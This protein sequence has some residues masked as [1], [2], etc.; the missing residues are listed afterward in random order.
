MKKF[1]KENGKNIIVI[2]VIA[3]L[4]LLSLRM[5]EIIKQKTL[6]NNLK[7]IEWVRENTKVE[8]SESLGKNIYWVNKD[9]NILPYN[10]NYQKVIDEELEKL[11]KKKY[12]FE[13][14]LLIL[15]PYGTNNLGLNIYFDTEEKAKISYTISVENEEIPDFSRTLN[16]DEERDYAKKHQYQLIGLVPEEVNTIELVAKTKDGNKIKNTITIDMSEVFCESDTILESVEGDSDEELTEGLYVL[17]GLDKA[18]NAN[19]Y[20]Y[21]NNGILRA[22]LVLTEY[23]SDRIIFD[24]DKLI[25]SYDTN[26]IAIIDRLGRIEKE[27]TL[28]EYVMHHD[29]VLDKKNNKLLILVNSKGEEAKTIEDLVISLNLKSGEITEIIDMKDLLPEIYETAE[30][31]ESGKN[32]YGGTGLDWIH[33]N[34]LSLIE[35]KEDVVL[36]AREI[37][38]IIYVEDIYENP[39]VKYLIADPSVYKNTKYEDLML[40]QIGDFVNHA[41]QHTI[42]Y[43]K[44]TKLKSGQYYL[45][46]YNNNYGASNTRKNFPWK[47]YPGVGNFE[48]G[49]SSKYYKYLVDENKNSYQLV[50]SFD[51]SYSSIVSSVQDIENNHIISSGKSNCYAEYDED[52][53]LI[54]Q[55]NY[56]S[57]KY[58]YRA[59]KY[60]FE[61]IWFA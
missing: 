10:D 47:E 37:S 18:F 22:D 15:N 48:E 29:Y 36:S 43:V 23:R 41:G 52:D 27:Y 13:E 45:E 42:T 20:L 24:D 61:D 57:K 54:K 26:G 1:I 50:E 21:D 35:E 6:E 46:M 2:I 53:K 58:A 9:E 32:T 49:D 19:N 60:T 38:T 25:Y 30:M 34:S 5:I 55:F 17:F 59:F 8:I 39:S 14:P 3:T 4:L 11:L 16:N 33:L 44:D 56:T 12:T 28:D 31:P 51:V 7:D 40:K